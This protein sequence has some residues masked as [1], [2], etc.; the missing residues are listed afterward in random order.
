MPIRLRED[1]ALLVATAAASLLSFAELLPA[2]LRNDAYGPFLQLC[3]GALVLAV[4]GW[5]VATLCAIRVADGNFAL[6]IGIGQIALLSWV[7]LRS[8]ASALATT[9]AGVALPVTRPEILLLIAGLAWFARKKSRL[10]SLASVMPGATWVAVAIFLI[11]QRELPRADMISSDPLQHAF[12]T[13]QVLRL[14]VVP[15]QLGMWGPADFHSP[16]GF[17]ALCAV[18]NW[19]GGASA[20]NAV[21]SQ[22][23]LQS[24]LAL[25]A[26]TSLAVGAVAHGDKRVLAVM[27]LVSLLLFF[28]F[29]PFSLTHPV[30][31]LE[32][33]GSISSLLLLLTTL[34]LSVVGGSGP[35][36]RDRVL[37]LLWA[38]AGVGMAAVVNPIAVVVPGLIY[39][40]AVCKRLWEQRR[41]IGHVAG[42][43]LLHGA[44]PAGLMFSDPYYIAR[45]LTPHV[46]APAAP[47]GAPPA[48]AESLLAA[49]AQYAESLFLTLQWTKPFLQTPYFGRTAL[50]IVPLLLAFPLAWWLLGRDKRWPTLRPLILAPLPII[51]LEFTLLP[52]FHTLRFKGDLYLLE[53]YLFDSLVR[54]GYLW[55]MAVVILALALLCKRASALKLGLV[56]SVFLAVLVLVPV[57]SARD[58]LQ[59]E[60]RMKPRFDRCFYLGCITADDRVVLRALGE[61]YS[62]YVAAGGSLEFAAVPKVLL[63]NRLSRVTA[64]WQQ[65]PDSF[66]EMWLKPAGAAAAVP[67]ASTFPAAFFY[68]K[69]S[70]EYNNDNY[71]AHVCRKLDIPWLRE[72]NIRYL[73][74]PANRADACVAGL[75]DLLRAGKVLVHSGNAA[76]I[77]LF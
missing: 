28:G 43:G 2:G 75:D 41:Q 16:A 13:S 31:L 6:Q 10:P 58:S 26:V 47:P 5:A 64:L 66:I 49:A 60:V 39:A 72:Q 21:A 37:A 19:V 38:G 33:T 53:P 22:P 36:S 45:L 57:R 7:Y 51:A 71:D 46:P 55:Y 23:L 12:F 1:G 8:S 25:L 70:E 74:V 69:G 27:G 9:F 40:G 14:G 65:Y 56:L 54:F 3:L 50:S 11:A 17:A 42:L 15:F 44:A 77:E 48:P 30:Y 52:W 29:F 67:F 76:L 35:Q 61:R 63:P 68:Y 24:T 73:I 59:N 32:K 20:L 34:T 18:W 4:A 62:A